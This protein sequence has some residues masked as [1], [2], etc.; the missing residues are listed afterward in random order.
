MF[1]PLLVKD[2]TLWREVPQS[3]I[4][5]QRKALYFAEAF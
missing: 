2:W 1:T 3:P 5:G 4:C